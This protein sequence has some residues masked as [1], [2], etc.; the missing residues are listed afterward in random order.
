MRQHPESAHVPVIVVTSSDSAK[1]K[2]RMA[3]FGISYY[4]RK[5]TEYEEYMQLGSIVK[6]VL[7]RQTA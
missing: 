7:E 4:F 3:Q 6:Q 2:E 5:P 1:D